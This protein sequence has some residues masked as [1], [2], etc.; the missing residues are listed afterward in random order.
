LLSFIFWNQD[1]SKGYERFKPFFLPA[2]RI[3]PERPHLTIR[4]R[5]TF[6]I[7]TV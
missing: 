6:I 7:P 4:N 3:A 1:I 2:A 5:P